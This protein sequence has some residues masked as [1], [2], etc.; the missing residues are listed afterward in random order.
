MEGVRN[1]K[2]SRTSLRLKL[3]KEFSTAAKDVEGARDCKLLVERM[4]N[5]KPESRAM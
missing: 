4:G 5:R 2:A 3:F 1:N